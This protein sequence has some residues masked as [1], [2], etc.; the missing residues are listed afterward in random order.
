MS[1]L[2][3]RFTTIIKAKMHRAM[4]EAEDPGEILDLS[5]EEQLQMLQKV[6][7][8]IADVATSK[9]RIQGQL[10]RAGEQAQHLES[11]ARQAL[12]LGREDLARTALER[13]AASEAQART[14]AGQVE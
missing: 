5:Y 12:S 13:K 3:G 11:Q 8:G 7:R 6:R 9:A 2:F 10:A 14:L 4:D 1:G